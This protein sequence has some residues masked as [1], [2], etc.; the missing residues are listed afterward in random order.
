MEVNSGAASAQKLKLNIEDDIDV[1][2]ADVKQWVSD[3]VDDDRYI[4][5]SDKLVTKDRVFS[6]ILNKNR[7]NIVKRIK[8]IHREIQLLKGYGYIVPVL[9]D[10]KKQRLDAL[11][12]DMNKM[13][14]GKFTV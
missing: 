4:F 9:V 5:S 7:A 10:T 6:D 8:E 3:D 2:L 14:L 1:V 13:I 11:R 12:N